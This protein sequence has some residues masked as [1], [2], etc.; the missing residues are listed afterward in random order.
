MGIGG[1]ALSQQDDGK[2]L[3]LLVEDYDDAREL[4]AEFLEVSGFR[5]CQARDGRQGIEKAR[6]VRPD[7][8]LMDLS[9]PGIDGWEA[10]ERLKADACTKQIPV[11]ALTGRSESERGD[12][13][14]PLWDYFVAKPC[15]PERL[16]AEMQRALSAAARNA[17]PEG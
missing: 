1:Q 2:P 15:Q 10:I 17:T 6:E 11:I 5:V 7:L 16:L 4:Y 14:S 12:R 13:A 3:V 9:L 8:I